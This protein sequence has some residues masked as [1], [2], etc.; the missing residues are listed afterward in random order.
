MAHYGL[1]LISVDVRRRRAAAFHRGVRA[2]MDNLP[3]LVGIRLTW[4]DTDKSSVVDIGS[5][6][7]RERA[8]REQREQRWELT[9]FDLD[10]IA[11]DLSKRPIVAEKVKDL[12]AIASKAQKRRS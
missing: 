1:P 10:R 8:L 12:K 6:V 4:P 11:A 3:D 9:D 7:R 5:E 2:A